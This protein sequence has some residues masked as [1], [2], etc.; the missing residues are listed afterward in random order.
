MKK[1]IAM[2]LCLMLVLPT[3]AL[4]AT[5][6][7]VITRRDEST[8]EGF[9][10]YISAMGQLDGTL[11]MMGSQAVYTYQIGDAD[12]TKHEYFFEGDGEVGDD[13]EAVSAYHDTRVFA[14]VNW[15]GSLAVLRTL[16]EEQ[17]VEEEDYTYTTEVVS[18]LGLF[19]LEMREDGTAEMD[20]MIREL[21]ASDLI[22]EE[23]DWTYMM[24]INQCAQAG[25]YLILS[26][27]ND[28]GE[29]F[30][31]RLS[32]E[33]GEGEFVDMRNVFSVCP[34][35]DGQALIQ[36][37]S[38]E[39][40][41]NQQAELVV[42][43][44]ESDEYETLITIPVQEYRPLTGMVYSGEDDLLYTVRSGSIWSVNLD[45]GEYTELTDMPVEVYSDAQSLLMDNQYYVAFTY[46][47]TAIR[48]L[49]PA[50][51]EK[52]AYTL[53]IY[54][55]TYSEAITS[56]Y[57]AYTN[58]H[59]EAQVIK[60]TDYLE[61]SQILEEMMNRSDYWD[62]LVLSSQNPAY[63][64]VF[65]RGFMAPMT[66]SEVLDAFLQSIYPSAQGRLMHDGELVGIPMQVSGE[67][68]GVYTR[69]LEKVGLTPDEI[70]TNWNDFLDFL[71]DVLPGKL[72]G[73]DVTFTDPYTDAD[74]ARQFLFSSILTDYMRYL[75]DVGQEMGFNTDLLRGVL[76]KLDTVDFTAL[77][78]PEEIDWDTYEWNWAEDT[79]LFSN[80]CSISMSGDYA[81]CVPL[82]MSMDADTPSYL[83]LQCNIA[84]INPF[85]AHVPEAIAFMEEM[86][87]NLDYNTLYCLIP[88]YDEPVRSRYY[89]EAKKNAEDYLATLKEQYEQAD[90]ENKQMLE[91]EIAD[92]E[93]YL[94]NFDSWYWDVS[95]AALEWF[96]AHDD[97]VVLMGYNALYG[98]DSDEIS[99]LAM[100]YLEERSIDAATFLKGLD[101]KLQM[102][103]LENQ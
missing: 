83:S 78:Q 23:D 55:S 98:S 72:E 37:Y 6:D 91:E 74:D 51:D 62:I 27:Y 56:A 30:V 80:W 46:Q 22:V 17:E 54:D 8:G 39:E 14:V 3:V 52:A 28:M 1:L 36:L 85:S 84:F 33:D 35:K 12:V 44:P 11:Y 71:I 18:G 25:D 94:E 96:R 21:D 24:Q 68:I 42:Y 97:S 41:K 92:Q 43:D 70:P 2:L 79:V 20:H 15:E 50:E 87:A 66:G 99:T 100:Q 32:L 10:D 86:T 47:G 16:T 5:G 53:R 34:Y 67:T 69:A 90:D 40:G 93:K 73:T 59:G 9:D 31:Y 95:P 61:P 102:M 57:F 65:N 81:N 29:N 89:E 75:D 88:A 4:A 19:A 58:K 48:N 7:A 82:L 26:G 77:G 45:S 60:S 101:K 13:T 103:I 49:K 38:Y 76:E 64:A 63:D